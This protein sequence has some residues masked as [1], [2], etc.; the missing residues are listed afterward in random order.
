MP[1]VFRIRRYGNG[2]KMLD[3]IISSGSVAI[4]TLFQ[5]QAVRV[6]ARCVIVACG[7]GR[8]CY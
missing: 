1:M 4:D 8:L 5:L 3:Y 6:V 7:L 2:E